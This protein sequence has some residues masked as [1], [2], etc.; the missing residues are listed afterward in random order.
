MSKLYFTDLSNSTWKWWNSHL[1]GENNIAKR[2]WTIFSTQQK[3]QTIIIYWSFSKCMN[4]TKVS[5]CY[6]ES[7]IWE[8]TFSTFILE[9]IVTMTSWIYANNT[10]AN[11]LIFGSMLSNISWNHKIRKNTTFH[12][13]CSNW[14]KFPT[15]HPYRSWTYCRKAKASSIDLSRDFSCTSNFWFKI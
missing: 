11:K 5:L 1:R 4:S 15:C 10:E 13:F 12:K 8:M 2:Y 3:N 7:S 6:V 9:K 14:Q